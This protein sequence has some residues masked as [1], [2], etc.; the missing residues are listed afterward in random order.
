M[1]K[2]HPGACKGQGKPHFS[3]RGCKAMSTYPYMRKDSIQTSETQSVNRHKIRTTPIS[4]K[5]K[6]KVE[7]TWVEEDRAF[8]HVNGNVRFTSFPKVQKPELRRS[9]QTS[10]WFAVSMLRSQS[11]SL[12]SL[13]H[14]NYR[15][16]SMTKK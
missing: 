15:T 9:F 4:G 1:V 8:V 10:F 6:R 14:E 5:K 2:Y 16:W 12:S 13:A 7:T 11:W 3:G